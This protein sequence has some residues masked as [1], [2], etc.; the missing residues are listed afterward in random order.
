M[1]RKRKKVVADKVVNN[2]EVEKEI[3]K[4][5]GRESFG[6]TEVKK[7]EKLVRLEVSLDVNGKL[8]LNKVKADITGYTE[9]NIKLGNNRGDLKSLI[10]KD[11]VTGEL[12]SNGIGNHMKWLVARNEMEI[13]EAEIQILREVWRMVRGIEK[14]EMEIYKEMKLNL[15]NAIGTREEKLEARKNNVYSKGEKGEK[16]EKTGSQFEP[17]N[18]KVEDFDDSEDI[19]IKDIYEENNDLEDND[20]EDNEEDNNEKDMGKTF[21]ELVNQNEEMEN[22]KSGKKNKV[23]AV[24]LTE[25]TTDDEDIVYPDNKEPKRRG[26]PRKNP[27][28]TSDVV[29]NEPKKR[30]RPKKNPVY[31]NE[32]AVAP[33]RRGRPRKN[34]VTTNEEVSSAPKKR[35]RGRPRKNPVM[36]DGMFDESSSNN[37]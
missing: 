33:K 17:E 4:D 3:V 12:V 11:V 23:S 18:E 35:G 7:K 21:V 19:D 10:N 32:V 31:S 28:P 13:R 29:V 26:R 16:G 25:I 36:E 6:D 37:F 20:L 9:K 15:R 30:G 8:K 5:L 24:T 2:S 27:V 14:E 1:G 22:N 34:P